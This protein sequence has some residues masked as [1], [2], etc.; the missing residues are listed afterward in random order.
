MDGRFILVTGVVV[1]GLCVPCPASTTVS[2][3]NESSIGTST[4]HSIEDLME[5]ATENSELSN[6]TIDLVPNNFTD[7]VINNN[8]TGVVIDNSTTFIIGNFTK[9]FIDNST[10]LIFDNSTGPK[11][12]GPNV[13][14]YMKNYESKKKITKYEIHSFK[15]P[16]FCFNNWKFVCYFV[17]ETAVPI[18]TEISENNIQIINTCCNGYEKTPNGTKCRPV[19]KDPCVWGKCISPN[20][21]SCD[22]YYDGPTC[23]IRI[24]CPLG[25][26]GFDCS[27]TC[28]CQNNATC[29]YLNGNCSCQQGYWGEYCEDL[30]PS[31]YYGH[32]CQNVCKCQT[33]A[34]C[35][36]LNGA[37]NCSPG[38]TGTNCELKCPPGFYGYNC[39][40]QCK[41]Q[42]GTTCDIVNVNCTCLP[43]YEEHNAQL[44]ECDCQNGTL[45]SSLNET[46]SCQP[47][48]EGNNCKFTCPPGYYGKT[49]QN[50]C[51]CQ[52]DAKCDAVNG[53]CYC[54]PGFTGE[55]CS[56]T[57]PPGLYGYQCQYECK[58]Q[59]GALCDPIIGSCACP[60]G[61][62]G[63][64]CLIGNKSRID[65]ENNMTVCD[66]NWLKFDYCE[67]LTSICKCKQPV[68]GVCVCEPGST[69]KDCEKVC[70]PG[71]YGVDCKST[72]RC[73]NE[74]KCRGADGICLCEPGFSGPTC[75]EDDSECFNALQLEPI[76]DEEVWIFDILVILSF[77]IISTICMAVLMCCYYYCNQRKI[78]KCNLGQVNN[79]ELRKS[80]GIESNPNIEV[81]CTTSNCGMNI[82]K[83]KFDSKKTMTSY[84]NETFYN[85]NYSRDNSVDDSTG[86]NLY[87]EIDESTFNRAEDL[88][89][90]LDF[91]RPTVSWKPHYQRT[92]VFQDQVVGNSSKKED[93][94]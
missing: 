41:Y 69:G 8:F 93:T 73:Q 91:L 79:F 35:D 28:Q 17:T 56:L 39:Q 24:G 92:L 48:H 13:C 45:C 38:Y 83:D 18:H 11:L 75:S 63:K 62:S 53:H 27:Q 47:G 64:N 46:C 89:D 51:K 25:K 12:T 31:G 84:T 59:N 32:K 52:N 37:C 7:I 20:V 71:T 82:G 57:C 42:N 40:N 4:V 86:E 1:F 26:F 61:L 9:F 77:L 76:N 6:N 22:E 16:Y 21:C 55:Y 49:C 5:L 70:P 43:G 66:C 81:I 68:D 85:N 15:T 90:H 88:Y 14:T 2:I 60:P 44:I 72:C 36:P 19:C 33:G 29:N 23:R 87:L 80:T 67:P 34:K 50:P 74:S 78:K 10:K 54:T 58:C 65:G 94:T 30:C 3:P